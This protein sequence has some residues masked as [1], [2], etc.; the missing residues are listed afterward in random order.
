M[1]RLLIVFLISLFTQPIFAMSI[2]SLNSTYVK[3]SK[4]KSLKQRRKAFDQFYQGLLKAKD[5]NDPVKFLAFASMK[6][7]FHGTKASSLNA[8][9]CRGLYQ[10]MEEGYYPRRGVAS[11]PRYL[12]PTIAFVDL[13]CKN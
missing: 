12:Y 2:E 8:S 13:I 3:I 5:P 10:K 11:A 9:R 4:I 7:V 1:Q 6:D